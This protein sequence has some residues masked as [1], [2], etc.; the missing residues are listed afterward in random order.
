[1][2]MYTLIRQVPTSKLISEQ[3][4]ALVGALAVAETFYKFQSFMLESLA[5]LATWFVFDWVVVKIVASGTRSPR[6]DGC[7]S[8]GER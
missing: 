2:N 1:M 6:R 5:F 4:P 3:L 7:H 8:R